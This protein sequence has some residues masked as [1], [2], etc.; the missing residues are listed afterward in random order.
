MLIFLWSCVSVTPSV[1]T[2]TSKP[3]SLHRAQANL[4]IP[5]WYDEGDIFAWLISMIC[6]FGPCLALFVCFWLLPWFRASFCPRR[7]LPF[8]L[9]CYPVK[10]KLNYHSYVFI[11]YKKK[12]SN[13]LVLGYFDIFLWLIMKRLTGVICV[14]LD[15]LKKITQLP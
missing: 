13:I 1:D 9:G 4:V 5:R 11:F 14:F 2:S 7:H 8:R 10:F 3:P 15:F 12:K 6:L